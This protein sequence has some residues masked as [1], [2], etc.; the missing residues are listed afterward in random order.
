MGRCA[1]EGAP[2]SPGYPRGR[3]M[4]W[5]EHRGPSAAPDG[6]GRGTQ[7][8]ERSVR[9]VAIIPAV[10]AR[11]TQMRLARCLADAFLAGEWTQ[12]GMMGQAAAALEPLPPWTR[13]LVRVVLA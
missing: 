12:A 5:T 6:A 7:D 3:R 13:S 10:Y 9:G 11:R 8:G 2:P 1:R 4:T